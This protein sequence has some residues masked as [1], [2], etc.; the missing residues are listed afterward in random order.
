MILFITTAVKTSNPTKGFEVLKAVTMK[1]TI[2]WAFS[3]LHGVTPE[4]TAFLT[5][6]L[7]N[8]TTLLTQ[9]ECLG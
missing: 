3:E 7:F 4:E 5:V 6:N 2:L 1:R 8:I 9:S